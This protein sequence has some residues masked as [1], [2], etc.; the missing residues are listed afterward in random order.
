M[1]G[2]RSRHSLPV[3]DDVAQQQASYVREGQGRHY[4]RTRRARE[5]VSDCDSAHDRSRLSVGLHAHRA[6]PHQSAYAPAACELERDHASDRV[7]DDIRA[8]QAGRIQLALDRVRQIPERQ[9]HARL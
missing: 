1:A 9:G 3:N 5:A 6:D 7:A 2:E 8:G 4:G